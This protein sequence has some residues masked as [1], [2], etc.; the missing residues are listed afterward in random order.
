MSSSSGELPATWTCL[1]TEPLAPSSTSQLPIRVPELDSNL[2]GNP[3]SSS[4]PP[5]RLE[6]ASDQTVDLGLQITAPR[7]GTIVQGR[8]HSPCFRLAQVLSLA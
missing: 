1:P 3:Q 7:D 4:S 8:R 2:D 6:R 5:L